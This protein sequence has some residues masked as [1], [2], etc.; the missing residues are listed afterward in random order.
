MDK[1]F[2]IGPIRPPSEAAS[3]LLRITR[4]CSWN[5]C[6]FCSIYRGEK[7]STRSL[8][9]IKADIDQVANILH[10]I[11]EWTRN[12]EISEPRLIN[13]ILSEKICNEPTEVIQ[14]YYLVYH[15][16]NQQSDSVFLQDANTVAL[17]FNKLLNI[18]L[19]LQEKLPQVKRVT[20][21]GRVDSLAKFTTTELTQLKE[22]GLNRIHSGFETGSDKVLEFIDK[23]YTK[24]QAISA[25]QNIKTAGI[26]LSIYFMPGVGGRYLS[27]DNALETADVI[28][29]V[30]PDFVRIRTFSPKLK[31]ELMDEITSGRMLP[32]TEMEKLL[33]IKTMIANLHNADG[34]LYS[35]H[36]FNLFEDVQGNMKTDKE[37]MLAIIE[38]FENLDRDTQRRY[39]LARR[40]GMVRL[41]DDMDYLK[42]E[43]IALLNNQLEQL[44]SDDKFEKFLSECL[45]NTL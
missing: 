33:E 30:N 8:E 44:N 26:E 35:D 4:N 14:R 17:S 34:Y 18:L 29:K 39:M 15:W 2:E 7:F 3:L 42:K 20:S 11:N 38:S 10:D 21:Y 5:R 24:A 19:Y 32:C 43:Q 12:G 41:L 37:K 23:G 16:L 28:N 45:I 31:T 6:K 13:K 27:E 9:D 36:T 40:I 25:G 1:A 22:A